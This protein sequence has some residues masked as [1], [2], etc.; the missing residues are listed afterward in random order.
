M[1]EKETKPDS[2]I[3]FRVDPEIRG[4]IVLQAA[5]T[6]KRSNTGQSVP[7]YIRRL[8]RKDLRDNPH[9]IKSLK[10]APRVD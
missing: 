1:S 9:G 8:I 7:D 4:D 2:Q 5:L 6:G 10:G 3:H